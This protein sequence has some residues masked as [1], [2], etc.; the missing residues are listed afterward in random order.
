MAA[1]IDEYTMEENVHQPFPMWDICGLE[2]GNESTYIII[3]VR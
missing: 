2:I 3:R 1:A